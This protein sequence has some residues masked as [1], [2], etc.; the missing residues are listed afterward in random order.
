VSRCCVISRPDQIFRGSCV[1]RELWERIHSR[2]R[3]FGRC[4]YVGCT[5]PFADESAPTDPTICTRYCGSEFIRESFIS[6]AANVL[7]VLAPSRMNPLPQ[8]RRYARTT[9]GAN[10]FAK[11]LF[12]TSPN[13]LDV[14]APSRMTPH[15]SDDIHALLCGFIREG[16]VLALQ[17]T[18]THN[19]W[20]SACI[21][22][23]VSRLK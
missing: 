21:D 9:V 17:Q 7:D 13:V 20:T 6:D 2:K 22:Q 8:I 18:S 5:G 14:L 3:Y 23:A 10:S 15:R 1:G 19:A 11:A 16:A 12:W 4:Q